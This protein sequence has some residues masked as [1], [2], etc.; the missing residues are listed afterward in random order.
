MAVEAVA[1]LSKFLFLYYAYLVGFP[2][3]G[4][5]FP[6]PFALAFPYYYG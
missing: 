4:Q 3:A 2:K 1:G 5:N 6:K